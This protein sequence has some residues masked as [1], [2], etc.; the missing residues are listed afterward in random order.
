MS[1]KSNSGQQGEGEERANCETTYVRCYCLT[2]NVYASAFDQGEGES[3]PWSSPWL[4]EPPHHL[5][6]EYS[7]PELS[8]H[9]DS[10]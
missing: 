7:W 5:F 9:P 8:D 3:P 10:R 2:E 6:G 4:E 1:P